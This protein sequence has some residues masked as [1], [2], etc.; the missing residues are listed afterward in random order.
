M[1]FGSAEYFACGQSA[2]A[3]DFEAF[4]KCA[5][6][7]VHRRRAKRRA[8][9]NETTLTN[10]NRFTI[11]RFGTRRQCWQRWFG[12][13]SN[14]SMQIFSF[15][16]RFFFLQKSV[17]K[18][19]RWRRDSLSIVRIVM[20]CVRVNCAFVVHYARAVRLPCTKIQKVG[21]MCCCR[22]EYPGCAK[23]MKLHAHATMVNYHLRN[24][25][26]NAPN[27]RRWVKKTLVH[28]SVWLSVMWSKYRACHAPM[29]AIQF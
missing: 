12:L 28:R 14:Q 21:T 1:R 24:F 6:K 10:T 8:W 15:L 2:F 3:A 16:F 5:N 19:R 18:E 13:C 27:T 26:S 4:P 9:R 17:A 7:F 25:F 11:L 20:N 22:A 23:P 29:Y